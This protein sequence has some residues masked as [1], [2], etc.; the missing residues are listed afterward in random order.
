MLQMI[1]LNLRRSIAAVAMT[2]TVFAAGYGFA[3]V[4]ANPMSNEVAKHP[5]ITGAVAGVATYKTLNAK[6][7]YDI[8]HGIRP[9]WAER[10]PKLSGFGVGLVTRHEIKKHMH[11]TN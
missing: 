3:P 9:N 10:H 2:T 6:R 8:A 4:Q 1:K 7:K 11:P 5:T